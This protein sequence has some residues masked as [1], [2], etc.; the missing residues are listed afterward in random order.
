MIECAFNEEDGFHPINKKLSTKLFI[1]LG[2]ALVIVGISLWVVCFC[3]KSSEDAESWPIML[4]LLGG[5]ILASTGISIIIN[6]IFGVC[7]KA[8]ML[9][10]IGVALCFTGIIPI[11][12]LGLW[13][14]SKG[15]DLVNQERKRM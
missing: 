4:K 12:I 15:E 2:L 14:Y 10:A 9:K 13:I 1:L 6:A 11:G 8:I 7:G 5:M 3:Q